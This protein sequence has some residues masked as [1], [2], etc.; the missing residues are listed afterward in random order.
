MNGG[1]VKL[2]A[3]AV[4]AAMF[5]SQL[6]ATVIHTALPAMGGAFEVAPVDLSIGITVYLLAQAA[7]LPASAWLADRFG[8]RR[9]FIVS[10]LA[11]TV[12]SLICG[13]T[14]TLDQFVA[15]RIL[16]GASGGLMMPVGTSILVRTAGRE[17]LVQVMSMTSTAVLLAPTFGPAIG[18][19][20]VT[21]LSWPWAFFINI[22]F[23]L[24]SAVLIARFVGDL[25]PEN[26]R[27][28]DMKGF[29]LTSVAMTG[30]L[31]GFDRISSPDSSLA[32]SIACLFAGTVAAIAAIRHIHAHPNPLLSPKPL[33]SEIFR[34]AV[35]RAGALIRIAIRALPFLLPLMFQ[36]SLGM[37]AFSAG[38]TLVMLNGADL[39]IKPLI[40]RML[41]RFG[42]RANI[43]ATC[44][45]S[46]AGT[47]A[48]AFFSPETP[49][50][51]VLVCLALV[52]A[53]RSILF[54]GVQTLLYTDIPEDE[55]TA[56]TVLWNVFQQLT[57]AI[58]VS[59]SAILLNTL[60]ALHGRWGDM[61]GLIDFR[62]ALAVN[63]AVLVI[64]AIWFRQLD[65]DAGA[66]LIGGK[67]ADR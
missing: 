46:A 50:W 47:A 3:V 15:A 26:P 5:M 20:C 11:F 60:A 56:A 38:L 67:M 63:A 61:P 36:L 58:A 13:L 30:L 14:T 59:I 41:R 12:S 8:A 1:P 24:L 62:I 55:I 28:F 34:I 16:Q 54:T 7:F 49:Y 31:I 43:L 44:A 33:R 23:G 37:S 4:A 9:I 53:A 29:I 2:T 66:Q 57:S 17:R 10:V 42:Y 51:V 19:F 48:C 65:R 52:G 25:P 39:V 32:L 18:G 6:D 35:L 27:P 22:P 21:Y 64:A 45:A 40:R